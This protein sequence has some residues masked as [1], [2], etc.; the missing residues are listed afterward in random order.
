MVL[1]SSIE[2][3][4]AA[5]GVAAALGST[6]S[7][8]LCGVLF[9]QLG[10]RLDPLGM[11]AAKSVAAAFLL[12]PVVI[13]LTFF[14]GGQA[15]SRAVGTSGSS[16]WLLALSGLLGIAI[17]DSLFFAAL[18]QLSPLLLSI[19]LLA[20][21]DLFAGLLGVLCLGEMPSA[22]VWLGI[23]AVMTAMGFLVI[24]AA[25]GE[26]GTVRSTARGI[27]FAVLSLICTS[28][29]MVIAKPVL[30]NVNPFAATMWRMAAG[31]VALV[32]FGAATGRMRKWR[33]AFADLRYA[34]GFVA[35]TAIVA[36]GGF[37]LSLAAVKYLDLV[38]ASA[39]M[40][41]EPLF[42]LPFMILFGRH[43]TCV[44]EVIAMALAVAGVLV[45]VLMG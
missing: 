3:Q 28:L 37:G 22:P 7:W 34:G 43:R 29:S 20:C 21:P 5:V 19:L 27:V 2:W 35:V 1:L 36:F 23:A 33:A 38:V 31:G 13:W 11:T 39:L 44:R 14:D 26:K 41:L 9:K 32:V 16:M 12:A 24:P 8:A 6:A 17:G 42:I 30:A 10:E 15:A 25:L 18:S 45:I 4:G 40:S